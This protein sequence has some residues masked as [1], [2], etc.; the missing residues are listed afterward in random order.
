MMNYLFIIIGVVLILTS[1][2]VILYYI[3]YIRIYPVDEG[4]SAEQYDGETTHKGR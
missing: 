3:G 1:F 2:C 4:G